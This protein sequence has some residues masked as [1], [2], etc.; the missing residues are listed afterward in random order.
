MEPSHVLS[1]LIH[2]YCA[3]VNNSLLTSLIVNYVSLMHRKVWINL[4][5]ITG[6]KHTLTCNFDNLFGFKV[7]PE[8]NRTSHCSILIFGSVVK[9]HKL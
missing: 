5:L 9:H 1:Q 3:L 4:Y 7:L 8:Q 2:V 6:V